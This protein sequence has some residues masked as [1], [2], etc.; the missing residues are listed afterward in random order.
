MPLAI[1]TLETASKLPSV[2]MSHS[3][4]PMTTVTVSPKFQVA[5]PQRIREAIGLRSG[6]KARVIYHR[7]RIE[8]IPVRQLR[9]L[10]GHLRGID[11][12]FTREGDRT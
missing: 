7:Y 4:Y 6:D 10:R 5:I 11:T 9:D 12:S 3:S 8:I 2:L 1:D